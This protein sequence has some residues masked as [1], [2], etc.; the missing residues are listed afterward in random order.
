M[1][2]VRF[3]QGKPKAF[4]F[5]YDD[6]PVQDV[7]FIELLDR[8]G[9]KCTFNIN[10]GMFS[11]T[12]YDV[13]RLSAEQ[14][15]ALYTSGEHEVATHGLNHPFLAA[16][17]V[18]EM[19]QQVREDRRNLE[20][21]FGKIVCG[22]A[23]PFGAY[24]DDVLEVLKRVGIV[25]S[26]TAEASHN[27]D[28]PTDWLRLS[29]TCPHSDPCLFEL[30]DTFVN[31]APDKEDAPW[32]FYVWG[33][34][35]EFDYQEDAW[36]RIGQ[37]AETVSARDDVWYATN[38]EIYRYLQAYEKLENSLDGKRIY[39]PTCQE[40]WFRENDRLYHVLPGETIETE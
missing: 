39:N 31:S 30:A 29:P 21:L 26:R 2:V 34:T 37:F 5:S 27:F 10:S 4:T 8:T 9:L 33:H 23:Y 40:I 35:Y 32:L 38:L 16:I 22:M 17:T 19:E 12:A 14:A 1:M 18:P 20:A 11:D 7:R 25:Y 28:L 13:Q 24:N 15:Q 6:G 3:P 36:E